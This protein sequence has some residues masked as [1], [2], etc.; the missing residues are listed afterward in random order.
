MS[1]FHPP[2]PGARTRAPAGLVGEGSTFR[3]EVPVGEAYVEDEGGRRPSFRLAAS[4]G[5]VG[6]SLRCD[7][8]GVTHSPDAP[9]SVQELEAEVLKLPSH[10]RAR[11]AEVLI[12]SLEEE[13]EIARAWAEEA[14]GSPRDN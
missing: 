7:L 4:S 12:A 2:E 14:G 11:L 10:E 1:L 5:V 9:M 6:L 8:P 3:A 13:D